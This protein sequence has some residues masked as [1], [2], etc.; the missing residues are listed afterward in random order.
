MGVHRAILRSA[1][2]CGGC[3]P[4]GSIHFGSPGVLPHFIRYEFSAAG[5]LPHSIS[6]F[7]I[8]SGWKGKNRSAEDPGDPRISAEGGRHRHN[9]SSSPGNLLL[10]EQQQ[11]MSPSH[12]AVAPAILYIGTPLVLIS[13]LQAGE[14]TRRR[15]RSREPRSRNDSKCR[16][17]APSHPRRDAFASGE[18][19]CQFD[20]RSAHRRLGREK[21][22]VGIETG[23]LSD[24]VVR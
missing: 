15:C 23:S 5:G 6:C 12:Q 16:L 18:L 7:R 9:L 2:T 10:P 21:I 20:E 1:S 17:P 13:T 11:I 4:R 22:P 8:R 19:I 14:R 3:G 24:H